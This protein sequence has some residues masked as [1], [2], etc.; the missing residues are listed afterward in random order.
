MVVST[1][2]AASLRAKYLTLTAYSQARTTKRTGV[3]VGATSGIGEACA[4]RLAEQGYTVIAVG[5]DRP[6]RAEAV[7]GCL[8]EASRKHCSDQNNDNDDTILPAHEFRPCDAFSLKSINQ[9]ATEI[10]K[11]H[12]VVD[13]LILT[14]G[15]ATIQSFTPTKEE[16]ND[17]KLTLHYWSRMAMINGLQDSLRKSTMKN[18]AVV[19]SVLSGG[20]H[21][22]YKK[23]QEDPELKQHYSI[24]NAANIA[25][26]YNDLG[27]DYLARQEKNQIVNFVHASPGF[28][29]TNWGTEFPWILR[30]MVRMMQPLGRSP[31]DCAEY[32]VGPTILASEAGDTLPHR[33]SQDDSAGVYIMGENGQPKGL[34][35]MHSDEARNFVWDITK[36]VLGRAGIELR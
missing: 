34:T 17:E 1:L 13:A 2:T 3:V 29:N 30:K 6:G 21:S 10:A 26:F 32:M 4:I 9:C 14:Q 25:G 24:P 18:G 7:V 36:Q 23:Y 15:M 8:K 31:S 19:V 11:D 5:R 16:G 33:P 35:D 27:L 28:V 22:P 12:P 20:V